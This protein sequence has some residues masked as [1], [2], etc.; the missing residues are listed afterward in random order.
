MN[1]FKCLLFFT[2]VTGL[3]LPDSP[4]Q[5]NKIKSIDKR[6][7]SYTSAATLNNF[8]SPLVGIVD[9]IW[10]GK[11]GTSEMLAG[12]GYG[13]QI[14]SITYDLTSYISPIITPEIAELHAKGEISKMKEVI[15]NSLLLSI[16]LG[17]VMS[18]F[19]YFNA[20]AITNLLI[21]NELDIFKYALKYLKYRVLSLPFALINS[22][23][24]GILRGLEDFNTAVWINTKSQIINIILDPILMYLPLRNFSTPN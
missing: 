5:R 1:L 22:T 14:F 8:I 12:S 24:F 23:I 16:I 18:I 6:I 10:V 4:V 7:I 9:G 20:N 21:S 13:D 3:S 2:S 17:S 19:T 11:L 15:Y